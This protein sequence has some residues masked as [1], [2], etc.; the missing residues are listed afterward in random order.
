MLLVM[1]IR[2]LLWQMNS[3]LQRVSLRGTLMVRVGQ[4]KNLCLAL[5]HRNWSRIALRFIDRYWIRFITGAFNHVDYFF[6]A[7]L[8][9]RWFS[10]S[11]FMETPIA[12]LIIA[13]RSEPALLLF[14]LFNIRRHLILSPFLALIFS[15]SHW[16]VLRFLF[17]LILWLRNILSFLL[18]L[19]VSLGHPTAFSC[20][21]S[22]ASAVAAASGTPGPMSTPGCGALLVPEFAL[23]IILISA[24]SPL[25]AYSL[26]LMLVLRA[27][28]EVLHFLLKTPHIVVD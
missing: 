19:T 26:L 28:N 21:L 10:I 18:A 25:F 27:S 1:G 9:C 11:S 4:A 6:K 3:I 14:D 13:C 24:P 2:V 22:L 20:A 7:R 17:I 23:A 15:T 16:S 8:S 5:R 12:V